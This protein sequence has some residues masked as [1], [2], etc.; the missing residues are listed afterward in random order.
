[1]KYLAR[2]KRRTINKEFEVTQD[3]KEKIESNPE[4]KSY[5]TFTPIPGT[6]KPKKPIEL[7][8]A[9]KAETKPK[10]DS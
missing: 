5:Y 4:L 9:L 7:D 1:M 8:P 2:H 10:K 6:E 3:Q